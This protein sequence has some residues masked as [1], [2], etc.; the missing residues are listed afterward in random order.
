LFEGVKSV[1]VHHALEEIKPEAYRFFLEFAENNKLQ[2]VD[3]PS[4]E[5]QG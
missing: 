3:L 4:T 2:V 5:S 1:I